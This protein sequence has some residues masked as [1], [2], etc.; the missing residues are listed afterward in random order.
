MLGC[1]TEFVPS[2]LLI[3]DRLE[4][5]PHFRGKGIGLQAMKFLI[6]RF[7]MGAGLVA[8]KPFPLQFEGGSQDAPEELRARGLD[9]YPA[10]ETTCNRKLRQ[11]YRKLGFVAIPRTPFMCLPLITRL[12]W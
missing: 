2:G 7:R 1:E 3:I 6:A 8:I 5:F 9:R 12:G 10:N 4:L 11:H